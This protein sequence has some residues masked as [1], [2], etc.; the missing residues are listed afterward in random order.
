MIFLPLRNLVTAWTCCQVFGTPHSPLVAGVLPGL[1][2]TG[3]GEIVG[4]VIEVVAVAVDGDA[5]GLAVPGTDRR[6]QI[7]DIVVDIDL[8]LDPV[9]HLRRQAL[10]AHIAL[11]RRAHFKD[12]EVDRAGRDRLLQSWVVVGLGKVDPGDFRARIGLPRFQEAAE[13]QVV[14]DSGC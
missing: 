10:A 8:L 5:I 11:E 6:L 1:G 7:V 3:V 9:R 12:V 2:Q 14:Q 4:P 13:Q